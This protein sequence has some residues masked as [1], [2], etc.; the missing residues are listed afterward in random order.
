[1]AILII[2]VAV[3]FLTG[4]TFLLVAAGTQTTAI[5]AEFDSPGS[6]TYYD[7]LE[8]ARAA[9]GNRG[10]VLPVAAVTN[11]SGSSR[12]LLVGVPDDP[13]VEFGDSTAQ[14]RLA[15]GDTTTLGTVTTPRAERLEGPTGAV[16]V[17]VQPRNRR[18]SLLAPS[19]YVTDAE[20]VKRV[21]TS[22]AFVVRT[23]AGPPGENGDG[24]APL[25]SALVFFITG[26]SEALRAFA[27]VAAGATVLV[28]ITVYSVSRM[29]VYDR[30]STIRI[31]RATGARPGTIL[32]LFTARAV[33]LTVVGTCL[34]Y[35]M[36]VV[37]INAVVNLAVALG[38]STSLSI[39]AGAR[40]IRVL[41][42]LYA[43]TVGLG[44]LA[45]LIA[46][47]PA[48]YRPPGHLTDT[49][50]A[51]GGGNPVPE[52]LAPSLLSWRTLVPTAATLTTFVAF[53]VLVSGMV[54]IA[55]PLTTTTDATITQP[56]TSNPI[57]S[58]V[59]ETY[60]DALRSRDIDASAEILL[61]EV[62]DGEPVLARG[63]RYGAFESVSDARL[64]RG[65]SPRGPAE[66]VVGVDLARARGFDVGETLTLGGSTET[67]LTRVE[68]VGAFVAAGPFDDQLLVSLP[69]ARH[70]T[71]VSQGAVQFVRAKR[72]PPR[73]DGNGSSDAETG[74]GVVDLSVDEP[75]AANSSF[76]AEVTLQNEGLRTA[77]TSIPV[78][79]DGQRRDVTV[80]LR[81]GRQR[82]V[83]VEFSAGPPGD[84]A[85]EAGNATANI[86]VVDPDSLALDGVPA[87]APP[88]SSPLV[89]V[90]N[91]TGSPVVGANVTSGN[92][93]VTT[94]GDGRVRVP[95][96]STGDT[97][98][99][100][101][102]GTESTTRFVNV[103]PAAS[104]DLSTAIQVRPSEPGLTTR[105]EARA[106]LTNPWARTINATVRIEGYRSSVER[107]VSVRPGE[108]GVVST[109]L[110]PRPPGSHEVSVYVDDG[111][112][113]TV[114]YRVTGDERIVSALATTGGRESTGISQAIEV[115]FGNFRILVGALLGL[116]TFMTVGGTTATFAQAVYA[117]RRTIGIHRATGAP[118]GRILRLVL[119]D[120]ARIGVV[121]SLVAFVLGLLGLQALSAVGYLTI[122]GVSL[123]PVPSPGVTIGILLGS[124]SVTLLGATLTTLSLLRVS[125]ASLL[126]GTGEAENPVAATEMN[127]DE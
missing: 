7:D 47:W 73:A 26:T 69:T 86:R 20:T 91:G 11:G 107:D 106:V 93:T 4:T 57:N 51:S 60:A 117:R 13:G 55:G 88:G 121:A 17:T 56:G 94:D 70:L 103:T 64:V 34:G 43:G 29:S 21:G 66:A 119:A 37:V 127:A 72:L 85:L 104:R 113:G 108:Q 41:G 95:L 46:A 6:A 89:T 84:Y 16:S 120:A 68:I 75:I 58:N 49:E 3:A 90:T 59:P 28:G 22:G 67:G 5:A 92:R 71:G 40:S 82:T 52:L 8:A 35:A 80:E 15:S 61:F 76:T 19:W 116:A 78:V 33:L 79:F 25:R 42:F 12:T 27:A 100:V 65:R 32:G 102:V 36:G 81:R 96:A 74:I 101:R 50:S 44:G 24:H 126:A 125:P 118:P 111:H 110:T 123:Q 83:R 99:T 9:A 122:F 38:V 115:V 124:L 53:A 62:V 54:G 109:R 105:P 87:R 48:A 97:E 1:L 23:G 98:V 45:G 30:L 114:A 39:E 63:V 18:A 10:T 112:V 77:R 2:A 14:L 31:V